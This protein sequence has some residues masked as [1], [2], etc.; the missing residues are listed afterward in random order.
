[1]VIGHYFFFFLAL[2]TENEFDSTLKQGLNESP[3]QE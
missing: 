3:R 2:Y 1:M